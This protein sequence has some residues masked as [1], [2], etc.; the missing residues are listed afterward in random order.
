MRNL[1]CDPRSPEL[2]TCAFLNPNGMVREP[3]QK[4]SWITCLRV[5]SFVRLVYDIYRSE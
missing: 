5:V 2:L 4:A 3:C 1:L